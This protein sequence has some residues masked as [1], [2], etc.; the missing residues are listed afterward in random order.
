MQPHNDDCMGARIV[1]GGAEVRAVNRLTRDAISG[2][3]VPIYCGPNC[4]YRSNSI[5]CREATIYLGIFFEIPRFLEFGQWPWSVGNAC[6]TFLRPAVASGSDPT[7]AGP[8]G[9]GGGPAGGWAM[10]A[11]AGRGSIRPPTHPDSRPARLADHR[12]RGSGRAATAVKPDDGPA[13]PTAGGVF[14]DAAHLRSGWAR[15]ARTAQSRRPLA[16]P[17]LRIAPGLSNVPEL[18]TYLLRSDQGVNQS[19]SRRLGICWKSAVL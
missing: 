14:D 10:G 7:T 2:T 13:G 12:T 8:A 19:S 3:I 5:R 17:Q 18:L 11:R 1:S 16:I 4:Q 6:R 15:I 9:D